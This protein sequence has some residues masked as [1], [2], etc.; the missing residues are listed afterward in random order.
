MI[1]NRLCWWTPGWHEQKHAWPLQEGWI[2]RKRREKRKKWN[3]TEFLVFP[4]SIFSL[5]CHVNIL[6]YLH[7]RSSGNRFL[8]YVCLPRTRNIS[9]PL[10]TKK[11]HYSIFRIYLSRPNCMQWS[12]SLS[13]SLRRLSLRRLF[14]FFETLIQKLVTHCHYYLVRECYVLQS[15]LHNCTW[16]HG[17]AGATGCQTSMA[18]CLLGWSVQLTD[19]N[20]T[21]KS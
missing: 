20:E 3:Q 4:F 10:T 21:S 1:I 19:D 14:S 2:T 6:L 13:A 18:A 7:K 17:Q 11:L 16:T 12:T 9:S 5:L 8:V 15:L